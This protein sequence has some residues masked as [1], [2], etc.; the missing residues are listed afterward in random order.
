MRSIRWLTPPPLAAHGPV[1]TLL[2]AHR[3]TSSQ[4]T[5]PVVPSRRPNP[6]PAALLSSHSPTTRVYNLH[7]T[8]K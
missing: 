3:L 2:V 5:H 6:T 7:P 4:A 1:R 8:R